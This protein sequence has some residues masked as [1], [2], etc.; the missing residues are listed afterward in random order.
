MFSAPTRKIGG[1][2]AELKWIAEYVDLH[3]ILIAPHGIF[4]GLVGLAA[5]VQM[6][7]IL[8]QNNIAFEYSLGQPERWSDIV[9]GL[10][11]PIVK[12]GFIDVWDK[13]DLAVTFNVP[14]A[15]AHLREEDRDFFD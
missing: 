12:N 9:D 3:G 13:P 6:G 1:G 15:K 14:A 2:M 10:P 4:D 7:A 5:E 8:P 11:D